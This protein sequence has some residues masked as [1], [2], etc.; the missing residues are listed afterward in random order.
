MH[1][2]LNRQLQ[3]Y[4]LGESSGGGRDGERVL[5]GW[6]PAR[7]LIIGSGCSSAARTNAEQEEEA[8]G[9]RPLRMPFP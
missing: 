4:R 5:P 9:G 6:R 1:S 2:L 3:L 8:G 7:V